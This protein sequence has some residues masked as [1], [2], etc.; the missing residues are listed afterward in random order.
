MENTSDST[1][2][3]MQESNSDEPSDRGERRNRQR[4]ERDRD[5]HALETAAQTIYTD[6]NVEKKERNLYV[7]QR[8]WKKE[9][10]G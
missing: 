9:K 10:I 1:L 3:T 6:F 4:C 8:Q 7:L 2:P 5:H